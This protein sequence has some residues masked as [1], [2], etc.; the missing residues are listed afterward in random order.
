MVDPV[1]ITLIVNLEIPENV[2]KLHLILG[3]IGYYLKFIQGYELITAPMEKFLKKDV[4]FSWDEECHKS[5]EL[6]KEKMAIVPILIFLNRSKV[7]HVH[8]D[9]SCIAVRAILA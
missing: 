6:L 7:F 4:T 1:K 8:V 9:T 3:H 5:F 2:K